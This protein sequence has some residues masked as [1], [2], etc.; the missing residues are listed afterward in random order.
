METPSRTRASVTAASSRTMTRSGHTSPQIKR[1]LKTITSVEMKRKPKSGVLGYRQ[2]K[3]SSNFSSSSV[4]SSLCSYF[5]TDG[6][7]NTVLV[8]HVAAYRLQGH[9]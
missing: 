7:V 2:S 6:L 9:F 8:N 3:N 4:G 1:C 5:R